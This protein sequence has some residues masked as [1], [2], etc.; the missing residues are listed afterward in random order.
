MSIRLVLT[1]AAVA[2]LSGG[3]LVAPAQ[4]GAQAGPPAAG[5]TLE[6]RLRPSGDPDGRGEATVRLNADR[7][8]VCA[9]ITWAN[10]QAPQAAH[11]HKQSNGEIVVD[12]TGA[13][14][15]GK[16]CTAGV[17]SG[18]IAKI[19]AHPRRYYVN[20]HNATYP[21]GAIQGTLHR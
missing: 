16:R 8:R 10:I 6:T 14:T 19:V 17:S 9:T 3:L 21:A 1:A 18:L 12:L 7:G 2:A 4:A 13:V 11:I 15:G 5:T 20:V